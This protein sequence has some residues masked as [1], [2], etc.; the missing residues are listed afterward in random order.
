MS[1]TA[2]D[3]PTVRPPSRREP[4][5]FYLLRAAV[6]LIVVDLGF[7]IV[8]L[9][10]P[11]FR[12]ID[13]FGGSVALIGLILAVASVIILGSGLFGDW[14]PPRSFAARAIQGARRPFDAVLWG[15]LLVA[16][17]GNVFLLQQHL[18]NVFPYQ[19][20]T[21]YFIL[22]GG[23]DYTRAVSFAAYGLAKSAE[24]V[25]FPG[26]IG[27]VGASITL[28]LGRYALRKT[29]ANLWGEWVSPPRTHE[30]PSSNVRSSPDTRPRNA[31]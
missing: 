23:L 19:R 6:T 18:M 17:A 10:V 26:S 12:G 20:G 21:R 11:T 14:Q 8:A 31:R 24:N 5:L 13:R 9:C 25:W 15:F 30:P 4:I 27:L 16:V 22:Y 29:H 7:A 28:L 2:D 3:V 1:D